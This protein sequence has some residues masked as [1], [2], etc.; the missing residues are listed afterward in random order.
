ME[1]THIGAFELTGAVQPHPRL[2]PTEGYRFARH[3]NPETGITTPILMMAATRAKLWQS[4]YDMMYVLDGE[5]DVILETSHHHQEGLP[6]GH[7]DLHRKGIDRCVLHST[8][9]D[10]EDHLL[11]DG[12]AGIAVFNRKTPQEVQFTEH[13][14]IICFRKNL[15]PFIDIC[16][17]HDIRHCQDVRFLTDDEHMHMSSETLEYHFRMLAQRLGIR[18][19]R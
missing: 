6:P 16:E 14:T 5:L 1:R 10:Y 3:R 2:T 4:F 12:C 9:I 19:S 7:I 13:K 17:K 18:R 8:L 11:Q 15:E